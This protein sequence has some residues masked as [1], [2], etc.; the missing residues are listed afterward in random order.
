MARKPERD[1]KII[2][3]VGNDPIDIVDGKGRL[4][5]TVSRSTYRDSIP[6]A[7]LMVTAPEM[8][9]ALIKYGSA[10]MFLKGDLRKLPGD[11]EYKALAQAYSNAQIALAKIEGAKEKQE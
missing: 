6:N 4:V 2:P 3:Y 8:Y 10:L 7:F 11:T 9:E 1:W 5:A